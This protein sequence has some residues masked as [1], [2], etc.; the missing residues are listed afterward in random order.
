MQSRLRDEELDLDC[1]ATEPAQPTE[2][3]PHQYGYYALG[4]AADCGRFMNC[5]AGRGY[6]FDCPDGLAYNPETLH[7]DWPDQVPS[8]DAE[9]T[10]TSP[11]ATAVNYSTGKFDHLHRQQ[12]HVYKIHYTSSFRRFCKRAPVLKTMKLC[13]YQ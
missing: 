3:C 12:L 13:C 1:Y 4:D 9:G 2:D 7:C 5:A 10:F 11:P 8:C 6:V